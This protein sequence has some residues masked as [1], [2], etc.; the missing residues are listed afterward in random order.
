MPDPQNGMRLYWVEALRATPHPDGGYEAESAH[1]RALLA[2]GQRIASVEIPTIYEGEPS[3]FRPLADTRR[4]AAALLAPRASGASA[5][6]LAPARASLAFIRRSWQRL[7]LPIA[8][9]LAIAALLPTLQPLDSAAFSTI[10]GLGDGPEPLYQALDPHTRN[11]I[12]ISLLAL[13]LGAVR[14]RRARYVAGTGLALLLAAYLS[15]AGLELLKLFVERARPEEI[16]GTGVQLSHDRSW[17]ALASFPSGHMVVT[18]ALAAVPATTLP[19]LRTA[20]I[21]Y[22][23]LVGLTRVL[24]GAHFPLD[25]LVGA[26]IGWQTGI[27]CAGLMASA[28]L[29][30]AEAL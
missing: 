25:V 13:V 7:A 30:P 4:I 12:L 10:N 20:L 29:L 9:A 14:L 16:L 1:L 2:A 24:F 3:H 28:R 6:T 11:Y 19:R 22:V 27:F 23:G 26:V 17:A 21:V 15:G 5:L 8:G 18:A